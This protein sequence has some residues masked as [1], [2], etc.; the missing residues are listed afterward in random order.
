MES[1]PPGNC[2][3]LYW[4]SNRDLFVTSFLDYWNVSCKSRFEEYKYLYSKFLYTT[5][6]FRLSGSTVNRP[7]VACWECAAE[8]SGGSGGGEVEHTLW[9]QAASARDSVSHRTAKHKDLL[10]F[11]SCLFT[12]TDH[13]DTHRLCQHSNEEV[14]RWK[15]LQQRLPFI[16]MYW[17][18]LH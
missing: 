3:H 8:W 9:C 12:P 11:K 7:Y 4:A 13:F 10:L 5:D 15:C 1:E 17:H 6:P 18:M 14:E 16:A 2:R